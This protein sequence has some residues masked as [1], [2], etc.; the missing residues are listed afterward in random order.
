MSTLSGHLTQML[1]SVQDLEKR[2]KKEQDDNQRLKE[3]FNK[4]QNQLLAYTKQQES[5]IKELEFGNHRLTDQIKTLEAESQTS[6]ARYAQVETEL[7]NCK[8]D[9]TRYRQYWAQVLD[10]EKEAKMMVADCEQTRK[11]LQEVEK[12]NLALQETVQVERAARNRFEK[13]IKMIQVEL[14]NSRTRVRVMEERANDQTKSHAAESMAA[15]NQFEERLAH[16][17]Q[18]ASRLKQALEQL[19]KGE[20]EELKRVMKRLEEERR[21]KNQMSDQLEQ[22][23][24]KMNQEVM[25]LT[26]SAL[27]IDREL[28]SLKRRVRGV[29]TQSRQRISKSRKRAQKAE[30]AVTTEKRRNEA[31]SAYLMSEKQRLE[32]VLQQLLAIS[33]YDYNALIGE[34]ERVRTQEFG[35]V[36]VARSVVTQEANA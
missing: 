16:A 3:E 25:R 5:R 11:T 23:R 12:L 28:T 35:G 26:Q 19:R 14:E 13:D 2:L 29:V 36:T 33:P 8:A 10:R 20:S 7:A 6:G 1:Q 17:N 32:A 31:M 15:K 24:H 27:K 18:E 4:R 30:L 22:E 9:L 34:I 21:A